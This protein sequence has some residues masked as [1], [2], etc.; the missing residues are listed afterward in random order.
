MKQ[1]NLS[2]LSVSERR[3]MLQELS[4]LDKADKAKKKEAYEAIRMQFIHDVKTR[5]Y[6]YIQHGKDFMDWI[7]GESSSFFETLKEYGQLKSND[8]LS[9]HVSDDSF[10]MNVKGQ[11]VKGFDERADIAEKRLIHFLDNWIETQ[12]G[13]RKNPMYKLAMAMIQRNEMGDLDYKSISRLYEL[14]ADFNDPEYTEVM[15]LFRESNVVEKTAIYFYF[16][17]KNQYSGWK[18]LE[19]SFN[20]FK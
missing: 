11:K 3:A 10:R 4:A 2:E 18:R 9:W 1:V 5:L 15:E 8:Q 19:P 6:E 17:E 14:E 16:E 13:G 7:R 12:E 20:K